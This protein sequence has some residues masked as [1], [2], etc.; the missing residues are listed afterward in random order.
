MC[1][2]TDSI[3]CHFK[4]NSEEKELCRTVAM[5]FYQGISGKVIVPMATCV[6]VVLMLLLVMG[7]PVMCQETNV[8]ISNA[9]PGEVL[10]LHCHSRDNDLGVHTLAYLATYQFSFEVNF[11]GTTLF[12]C[13][14]TAT[15]HPTSLGLIVFQGP[16][17]QHGP[18]ICVNQCNW[19]AYEYGFYLNGRYQASWPKLG[20]DTNVSTPT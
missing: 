9:M 17:Y 13:D 5:A 18:W 7:K 15:N 11:W 16:S 20:T 14:F 12:T 2:K 3:P 19:S 1:L 10:T 8:L 4:A 6:F